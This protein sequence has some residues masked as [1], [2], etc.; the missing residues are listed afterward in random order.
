MSHKPARNP[1]PIAITAFFVTAIL[2]FIAFIG[3]AMRQREDLVST[4]YYER[5]IR[6]QSQ[7][8]SMNRSQ[9][10]AAQAVVTF[11]PAQRAI[12]ITLPAAQTRGATG[13]IQLY[14]PS[15]ARLDR[16]V[17]LALNAEGI[18]RLDARELPDG[19]WKVRVKWSADGQD[20][21][22]DQPVI[23]AL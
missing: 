7:L 21:F 6:Y 17:A 20:Y 5:E 15:D 9:S 4:D 1:W 19:L 23:L 18:Q 12:V 13:S 22:V 16:N 11:E 3:F 8:D 14:R 10:L 2:F